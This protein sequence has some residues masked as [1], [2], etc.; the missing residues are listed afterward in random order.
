MI[1]VSRLLLRQVRAAL[2]RAG[3]HKP[4]NTTFPIA[5]VAGQVGLRIQAYSYL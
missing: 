3:L 4:S 1:T 2:R 5:F